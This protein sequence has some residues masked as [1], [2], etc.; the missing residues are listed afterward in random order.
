MIRHPI[1]NHRLLIVVNNLL[2][3]IFYRSLIYRAA[4]NTWKSKTTANHPR[5]R[6]AIIFLW[7]RCVVNYLLLR[8]LRLLNILRLNILWLW[9]LRLI[10]SRGQRDTTYFRAWQRYIGHHSSADSIA[11][12]RGSGGRVLYHLLLITNIWRRW[13]VGKP[14]S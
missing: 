14:W 9:I 1:H 8:W 3:V 7:H 12:Y 13:W 6:P 10:E 11:R 5:P 4:R 2:R